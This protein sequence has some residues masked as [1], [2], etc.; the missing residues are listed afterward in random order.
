MN[1][2]RM[3]KPTDLMDH[4]QLAVIVSL[5][6]TLVAAMRAVLAAHPEIYGEEF[7]REITEQD[8]WADRMIYLGC[9]L[10]EAIAKYR[11]AFG[12]EVP[13]FDDEEAT[14]NPPF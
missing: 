13:V 10:Q 1:L 9:Q 8:F 11:T 3:P 7:P 12:E 4:P 14:G 2:D 6:T 5:E